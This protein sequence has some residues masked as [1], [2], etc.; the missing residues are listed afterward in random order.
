MTDFIDLQPAIDM[1]GLRLVL[2]STTPSPWGE[3][4]KGFFFVKRIHYI[5]V[6]HPI[7]KIRSAASVDRA[8][9]RPGGGLQ[10]RAPAQ[11]VA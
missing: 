8:G 9:K 5:A 7:E 4:V 10:R 1:P 11:H 6:R 2:I 3:A